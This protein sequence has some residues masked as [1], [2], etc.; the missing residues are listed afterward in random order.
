MNY[1]N[2]RLVVFGEAAMFTT[3]L[4][5][6]KKRKVGMNNKIAS[7]NYQLLLNIIHWLDG[8]LN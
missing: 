7:E 4:V 3:Q 8:I 2:G 5:G 6:K 1:G